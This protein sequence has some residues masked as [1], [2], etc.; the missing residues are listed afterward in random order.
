MEQEYLLSFGSFGSLTKLCLSSYLKTEE[1]LVVKIEERTEGGTDSCFY[2][3]SHLAFVAQSFITTWIMS[4]HYLPPFLWREVSW[5]EAILIFWSRQ[6]DKSS[7]ALLGEGEGEGPL[8]TMAS[9]GERSWEHRQQWWEPGLSRSTGW[10]FC[11]DMDR[12]IRVLGR[13]EI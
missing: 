9:I 13:N 1:W 12:K 11:S 2:Y 7:A 6:L 3:N 10:T 5:D 4:H 8:E